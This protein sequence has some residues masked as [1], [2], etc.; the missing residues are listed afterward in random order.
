MKLENSYHSFFPGKVAI[1][2][3]LDEYAWRSVIRAL[4]LVSEMKSFFDFILAKHKSFPPTNHNS[5]QFPS[6]FQNNSQY[7]VAI[8]G[9][10]NSSKVGI[11]KAN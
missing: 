6:I 2:K 8:K 4:L 1:W 9:L 7:L 11:K 3:P 5:S 10:H